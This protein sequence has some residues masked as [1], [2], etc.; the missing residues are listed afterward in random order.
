MF[1]DD[2]VGSDLDV[3]PNLCSWVN[4]RGVM[5]HQTAPQSDMQYA[6]L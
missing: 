1:A 3:A 4:D 6:C 5:Q 2:A